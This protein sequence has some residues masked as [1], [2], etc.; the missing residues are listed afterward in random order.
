MPL[1]D[2]NDPGGVETR[3]R[4]AQEA[5]RQILEAPESICTGIFGIT[6]MGKSNFA[7]GLVAFAW[8][9]GWDVIVSDMKDEY[10]VKGRPRDA[11]KLGTL[12]HRWTVQDLRLEPRVLHNEALQ[13]AVVP[14]GPKAE[15]WGRAFNLVARCLR[16]LK[17]RK[18]LWVVEETQYFE[19]YERE[20]VE[21]VATQWR[22]FNVRVAFV[23]QRAG[24]IE[25]NASSQMGCIVSFAQNVKADVDALRARTSQSDT[26]YADRVARLTAGQFELWLQGENKNEQ[27]ERRKQE[28]AGELGQ[29]ANRDGSGGSSTGPLR[30]READSGRDGVEH[31][32]R[33][34]VVQ[35]GGRVRVD[36]KDAPGVAPSTSRNTAELGQPPELPAAERFKLKN[37]RRPVPKKKP[38]PRRPSK[39]T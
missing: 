2:P 29:R 16:H 7:K 6:N 15:E 4:S 13:L 5:Y 22:D 34:L 39:E 35:G 8:S 17:K 32:Q 33:E 11:V 3:R 1:P 12:A 37:R 27:E 28:R 10:S 26:Y 9:D 23:S 14:M 36:E 31:E 18:L 21:A 30:G 19:R 25:I 38:P 20:W 24:G